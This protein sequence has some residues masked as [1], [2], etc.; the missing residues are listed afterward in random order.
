MIEVQIENSWKELLGEEFSKPYFSCLVEKIK[1]E[2]REGIRVYPPGREIFRAFN[3][4]PLHEVKVVILGQDPYHGEGQANGL[5]FSVSDNIPFPP[6]L[7]NIFKEL[8]NDLGK[9]IPKSGDLKHWASQGVFLLNAILT[10]R[11]GQ[12]ASHSNY[13]WERFTDHVISTIS[14][15]REGIIFMLWG[16]FA[17]SKKSLIN[18]DSHFILESA[19]PSPLARGAFFGSAHFSKANQI[20]ASMGKDPIIW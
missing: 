13:G 5:C 14:N 18:K 3:L 4:T 9:E 10:V 19:H 8:K 17:K 6:S 2:K 11:A 12:P 15:K 20:L 1:Q 16:N 7:H